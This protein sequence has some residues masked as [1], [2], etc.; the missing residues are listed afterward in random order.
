MATSGEIPL[1]SRLCLAC[2][3]CCDGTVHDF[4]FLQEEDM[5]PASACGFKTYRREDGTPAMSLPC[6]YLDGTACQR[7]G[8][9]RPSICGDYLCRLQKRTAAGECDEQE[10]LGIIAT[11][12]TSLAQVEELLKPDETLAQARARF[13]SLASTSEALAPED[14]KLV[15]R[16]FVL[17]RLLDQ[18]FRKYGKGRLPGAQARRD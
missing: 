15:V 5:A 2:G 10:A 1:A 3:M 6:H 14:A 18:H 9:W 7:Y 8:E 13:I 16:L 17:E 11:A 4:A 12:K